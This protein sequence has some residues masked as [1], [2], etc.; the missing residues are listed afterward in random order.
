MARWLASPGPAG[1]HPAPRPSADDPL[2]AAHSDRLEGNLAVIPG[3]LA[4]RLRAAAGTAVEIDPKGR[5]A[6]RVHRTLYALPVVSPPPQRIA[7]L[8]ATQPLLAFGVGLGERVSD[9]LTR[10]GPDAAPLW[11]WEPRAFV[12]AEALVATGTRSTTMTAA[13]N[14]KAHR[15]NWVASSTSSPVRP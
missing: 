7:V 5:P 12:L 6:L 9:L 3:A 1:G 4:A 10:R 15:Q 14:R 11:A 13:T 2:D 8:P